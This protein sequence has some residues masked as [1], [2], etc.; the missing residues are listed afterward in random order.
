MASASWERDRPEQVLPRGRGRGRLPPPFSPWL[1]RTTTEDELGQLG[2]PHQ[3]CRAVNLPSSLNFSR[4]PHSVLRLSLIPQVEPFPLESLV[5]VVLFA[6][7]LTSRF[8]D[9]EGF[10]ESRSSAQAVFL[11]L[12]PCLEPWSENQALALALGPWALGPCSCNSSHRSAG[13]AVLSPTC[14][15]VG[16]G[17]QTMYWSMEKPFPTQL[18]AARSR[19]SSG[20]R[21]LLMSLLG[22]VHHTVPLSC[23]FPRF[24]SY[25]AARGVTFFPGEPVPHYLFPHL[26]L[27]RSSRAHLESEELRDWEG[28]PT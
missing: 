2:T 8:D 12:S 14:T 22:E 6:L 26:D 21:C 1:R 24:L 10:D 7:A 15:R 17:G 9:D 25:K 19:S 13:A 5:L 16:F 3:P 27:E 23:L 28:R 4:A 11:L 18:P 20:R